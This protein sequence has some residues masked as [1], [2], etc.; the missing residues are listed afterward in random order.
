MGLGV[1]PEKTPNAF[2]TRPLWRVHIYYLTLYGYS[3]IEWTGNVRVPSVLYG[4][5]PR[6]GKTLS[7]L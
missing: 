7:L 1:C 2:M 4:D 6:I 3:K 5:V